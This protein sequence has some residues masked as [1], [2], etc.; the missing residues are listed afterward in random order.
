M[1]PDRSPPR[2]PGQVGGRGAL[3]AAAYAAAGDR[4]TALRL[5]RA[6]LDDTTLPGERAGLLGLAA[7]CADGE[8]ADELASA[9]IEELVLVGEYAAA[10][11]L[12]ERLPAGQ[13]PS[14]LSLVARVRWQTGDDEGALVAFAA[15]R[16]L[17]EPGGQ[18]DIRLRCE[19]ARAIALSGGDQEAALELARE[20]YAL[21]LTTGRERARALAVLGTVEYFVASPDDVHH[22]LEAVQ[23]LDH[24]G[25]A[26][27][28]VVFTAAN[29]LVAVL[30][31]R[32]QLE[33]AVTRA[34]EAVRRADAMRMRGWGRQMQAMAL[35]ARLHIGDY[36]PIVA[37]AP[38]LLGE[39]LDQRTR[40]QLEV[41]L[42]LALV[43][44]GRT[45]IV[46]ARLVDALA[47]C[48][49][50]HLGRG[51]LLWVSS[52]ARLWAGD[53]Q[54]ALELAEQALEL[55]PG[56]LDLFPLVTIAHAELRLGRAVTDRAR[57][58]YDLPVV[59]AVPAELAGIAAKAAGD[60][61]TAARLFAEA[62]ALWHGRHRRGEQRCRWLAA[63]ASAD[64]TR[65]R[66]E[67]EALEAD[68]LVDGWAPL[69]AAVR[70]SLRARGVRRT[71]PRG[72]A[73]EVTLRE[74]EVLDLI[75]EGLS[76]DAVAARLGVTPSTVAALVSSARARLG[77]SNR[78]QAV[79]DR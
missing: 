35:N 34:E 25:D 63:D 16:S 56:P 53:P 42:G 28:Q 15:A 1:P 47:R 65:A 2:E 49:D 29:N 57:T 39:A 37:T 43:D 67:L 69:L 70:R 71:A 46:E 51:N 76:T 74:R 22:L 21:S 72:R 78:W 17:V 79:S 58:G 40:D 10:A 52:E 61:A 30:E 36:G 19:H 7:S 24:D 33:L 77:A 55:L 27:L 62:A 38:T 11:K 68:L 14:W 18:E 75:A 59:A 3:A 48:A 64:D 73:G 50:D 4:G 9:A 13:G 8:L 66:G 20:A 23:L 60:E 6:A 31:A 54:H 12:I 26:D 32:G 5:A 44:L 41:T 45:E